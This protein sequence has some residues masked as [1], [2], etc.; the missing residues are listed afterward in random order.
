MKYLVSQVE[1]WG[2]ELDA[3]PAPDPGGR[4]VGKRAAVQLLAKKLQ[5]AARRGFSTA[6]LLEVLAAKGLKVHVDTLRDA[7]RSVGRTGTTPAPRGRRRSGE[8]TA[9]GSE[10][11]KAGASGDEQDAHAGH[12]PETAPPTSPSPVGLADEHRPS[13]DPER[14][15][16]GRDAAPVAGAVAV[17]V[18]R[19][20]PPGGPLGA[21]RGVGTAVSASHASNGSGKSPDGGAGRGGAGGGV[22]SRGVGGEEGGGPAAGRGSFS[23]RADSEEI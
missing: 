8:A 14:R 9:S 3:L 1:A 20:E 19:T 13:E 18:E 10:E 22:P 2:E 6:E 23:P 12:E 15:A 5:A 11:G 16:E 21:R 7:L 4:K 17:A